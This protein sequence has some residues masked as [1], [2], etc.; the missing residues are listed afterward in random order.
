D[1]EFLYFVVMGAPPSGIMT[2]QTNDTWQGY[3]KKFRYPYDLTISGAYPE[4]FQEPENFRAQ[5]KTNGSLHPNGGGWI[6]VGASVDNSVYVGPY[7]IVRGNSVLTGNV[8]IENT[9]MLYHATLSGNAV[10]KDNPL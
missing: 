6:E 5:I 4:G 10:V 2:N 8:R 7:A 9:A 1:E 3:P